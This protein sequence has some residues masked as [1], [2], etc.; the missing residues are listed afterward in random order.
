MARTLTKDPWRRMRR[1]KNGLNDAAIATVVAIGFLGVF[2]LFSK[3]SPMGAPA[4][5]TLV[6]G[7]TVSVNLSG[8]QTVTVSA[9][10]GYELLT[11]NGSVVQ[12]AGANSETVGT[13]AAGT[14]VYTWYN[15]STGQAGQ[16]T[17][18]VNVTS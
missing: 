3:T 8:T 17:L 12:P 15:V 10:A 1:R 4:A 14:A 6:N 16:G 11:V 18:V 7:G 2:F 13:G 9:P 5:V